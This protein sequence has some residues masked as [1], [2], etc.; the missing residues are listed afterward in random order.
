M[1]RFKPRII[2]V[3]P[4]AL[5]KKHNILNR[6]RF[7]GSAAVAAG[8]LVIP[9][10]STAVPGWLHGSDTIRIALIGCGG[11]GTT[12]ASEAMKTGADV[13]LVAMADAFGERMRASRDN[14]IKIADIRDQV[15]VGE[16]A[17]F[18]GFDAYRQAIAMADVV[19]L[20]APPGFR[21]LHF[22]EAI[23]QG[24]HVFMEK[25]VAVDPPGVRSILSDIQEAK[26]RNLSVVVGLQRRFAVIYTENTVPM[27]QGGAIGDIVAMQCWWCIGA[28]GLPRIPWS[29]CRNEMDYQMRN[30]YH[31][32]WLSGDHI[33]DT[34]IHN[35]DVVNWVKQTYPVRAQGMGGRNVP[36]EPDRQGAM[37]DHHYVEFQYP[38]GSYLNSQARI[39][40][41]CWVKLGEHFVGTKGV[42]DT[43]LEQVTIRE[44]GGRELLRVNRRESQDHP[45]PQQTEHD[46]FFAAI[47]AGRPMNDAEYGAYS[48]MTS[49]LGRMASYSGQM[50]T[51]EEALNSD[52]RIGPKEYRWD[53]EPPVLPDEKGYY[54]LPVPGKSP[55]L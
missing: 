53:A 11:R 9:R 26:R 45:N 51:W 14:L 18:E 15:E 3:N 38:D 33:E 55:G 6:R 17:M 44:R 31:F 8:A 39:I 16:D 48:T 4:S 46:L 54:P 34:H 49:I 36:Y 30:W 2:P 35:L 20:A 32:P 43:S 28:I 37:F 52:I 40:T 21:P 10:Q 25:P 42:A 24:K 5:M 13:R 22:A 41:G 7:I 1:K 23:R 29:Q 50:V 19:L 12:A 47:R 27:L